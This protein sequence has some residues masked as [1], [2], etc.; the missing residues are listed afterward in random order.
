MAIKAGIIRKAKFSEAKSNIFTSYIDYIDREEAVF[1]EHF[2]TFNQFADYMG[3]PE[4]ST[5]LFGEYGYLSENEKAETKKI[6]QKAQEEG[7]CLIQE[8]FSFDAEWIREQGIVDQD[9]FIKEETLK[10][11]AISAIQR[12][13]KVE[14]YDSAFWAASIHH[15]T[16]HVHIHVAIVDTNVSWEVGKGRC[17]VDKDGKPRQRGM[18]TKKALD[19]GASDLA[20]S[21]L[22]NKDVNI[23]IANI[24]RNHILAP[25][26]DQLVSDMVDRNISDKID[27]LLTLLPE[28][29]RK[30]KYNNNAL[31][32]IRPK[33]DQITDIFIKSYYSDDFKALNELLDKNDEVYKMVY[34][35]NQENHYKDDKL[36]DL[37]A[38]IGNA[39]LKQ[40]LNLSKP[41]SSTQSGRRKHYYD[42]D[43]FYY[44]DD[45]RK[46]IM[47]IRRACWQDI[48]HFKNQ[49]AYERTMMELDR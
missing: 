28:D 2:D 29:R 12:M 46:G 4:K 16:D 10:N 9:G 14:K 41:S 6:F 36:R 33:I 35:D 32:T 1:K 37:Y 17:T 18:L 44:N 39:I 27:E 5:G 31:Q 11:Y 23:E 43:K 45:L 40:C 34:G 24:I 13:L 42:A 15:N 25:I 38:R 48:S 7:S 20:N 3:N 47:Y 8:V 22:Q 21:I 30:W 19:A 26:K 49:A